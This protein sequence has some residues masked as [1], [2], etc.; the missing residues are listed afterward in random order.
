MNTMLKWHIELTSRCALKCSECTRTFAPD[1]YRVSDLPYLDFISFFNHE[2]M[3]TDIEFLFAGRLGDSIYHPELFRFIDYIK[4]YNRRISIE[5]NGSHRPEHWWRILAE[6]LTKGDK[7]TFSVDGLED[8]NHLYRVN[9]KWSDI[10]AAM[11]ICSNKPFTV[12]WKF[13]VFRHN[14]HQ[15]EEANEIAKD[16]GFEFIVYRS[17]RYN[18]ESLLKPDDEFVS[19]QISNLKQLAVDKSNRVMKPICQ[20]KQMMFISA[21]GHFRPCCWVIEN[22]KKPIHNDDLIALFERFHI[23]EYSLTDIMNSEEYRKFSA[24]VIDFETSSLL[25]Q[26][27]CSVVG[28]DKIAVQSEKEYL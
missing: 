22:P 17:H 1:S 23:S 26:Q 24:N 10:S 20:Q 12:Q 16:L 3:T 8:T 27:K 2:M 14:Q 18:D 7:L 4:S 28:D 19:P 11:N 13:I 21:T 15:I 5:T 6:K 9:S 25:C